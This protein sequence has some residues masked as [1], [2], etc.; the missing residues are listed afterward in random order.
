MKL[1]PIVNASLSGNERRGEQSY[2]AEAG[3]TGDLERSQ[4]APRVD[5]RCL[6]RER[7]AVLGDCRDIICAVFEWTR[8]IG[9][10]LRAQ[11]HLLC[12]VRV[13]LTSAI[14]T[15]YA[16]L[17]LVLGASWRRRRSTACL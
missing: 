13:D 14:A 11:R 8:T 2:Q 12:A 5:V 17:P 16:R 1:S 10:A 15:M 3:E 9:R 6:D 7:D 4:V